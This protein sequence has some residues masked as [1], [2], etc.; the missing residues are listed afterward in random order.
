MDHRIIY[1]TTDDDYDD[2]DDDDE[3]H[4]MT[5]SS[6]AVASLERSHLVIT[7]ATGY[8]GHHYDYDGYHHW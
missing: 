7:G 5:T 2:D 1:D 6:P 8:H 4:L 3:A